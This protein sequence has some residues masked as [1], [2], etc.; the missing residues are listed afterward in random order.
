ML[1][2]T[3][4]EFHVVET[5]HIPVDGDIVPG[6]FQHFPGHVHADGPAAL[7]DPA[8]GLKHV[9]T[10]AA[11]EIHHGLPLLQ[12]SYGQRIAAGKPHVG[13]FRQILQA[14]LIIPHGAGERIGA[15]RVLTAASAGTASVPLGNGGIPFPHV[16]LHGFRISRYSHVHS[17]F[18]LIFVKLLK[19]KGPKNCYSDPLFF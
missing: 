5:C 12:G 6:L 4:P 18:I 3:E 7:P 8:A 9:K 16:L 2:L 13:A 11:A 19:Y 15:H 1:N 10:A 14:L 17:P